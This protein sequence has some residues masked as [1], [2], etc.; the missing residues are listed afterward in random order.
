MKTYLSILFLSLLYLNINYTAVNAKKYYVNDIIENKLTINKKFEMD[1]PDGKWVVAVSESS[2]YYGLTGKG[3]TLVRLEDNLLVE[4]I[5]VYEI[6]TAGI[7]EHQVNQAI[8][9]AL[10]RNKYDGC[11][12]RP[13][14]SIIKFYAR[15]TTHNCFWI[16]HTDVY[17]EL[18]TPDDPESM[19]DNSKFM[20]WIKSNKVQLPKVA[21]NSD[22]SYFSRLVNGKW[23]SVSYIIDPKILSAPVNKFITE[24]TSEYHRNNISNYPEYNKIMEKWISISAQRH[25][26]FE[27]SIAALKK[28]RLNLNNLSPLNTQFSKNSS[29]KIINQIQSLNELFKNGII[30]QDEFKKAKKKI[31]N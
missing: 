22:H 24:E 17:K 25:I 2:Y 13:E 29:N 16:Y 3:L 20:R 26:E 18:F 19:S 8:N 4:A 1:L 5:S 21:L 23:F 30:T 28:H 11:Y 27:N 6:K 15:G 12:D 7:Y 9:E 14:Y 10:F 31:L